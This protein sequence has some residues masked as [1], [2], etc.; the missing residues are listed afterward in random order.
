MVDRVIDNFAS[1]FF[2]GKLNKLYIDREEPC[3]LFN[4]EIQLNNTHDDFVDEIRTSFKKFRPLNARYEDSEKN[5]IKVV[6]FNLIEAET[7][8]RL[9]D[10]S[11][12]RN[13][14]RYDSTN[15]V[16]K[17]SRKIVD[18]IDDMERTEY[19]QEN[20]KGYNDRKHDGKDS[21]Q[22]RMRPGQKVL[23]YISE[24]DFT[25]TRTE[26]PYTEI[27]MKDDNKKVVDF[28]ETHETERMRENI[29]FFND[30]LAGYD[31]E[32]LADE[33]TQV[34]LE[35]VVKKKYKRNKRILKLDFEE[36]PFFD[37]SRVKLHRTFN[38]NSFEHGGRYYGNYVTGIFSKDYKFRNHLTIN[39]QP[40][41]ELDFGNLHP[42]M[43]YQLAGEQ[44]PEGDMYEIDI[45]NYGENRSDVKKV[46]NGMLNAEGQSIKQAKNN[47][48][49]SI[50]KKLTDNYTDTATRDRLTDYM[51]KLIDKHEAIEKHF[52]TGIAKKCQR[53]DSDIA[54]LVML[55][56]MNR[57]FK[58]LP[59][60]DSFIIQKRDENELK[61]A[62]QKA[63]RTVMS[64]QQ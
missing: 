7:T 24:T 38:D 59:V 46:L 3:Y 9:H 32:L 2:R 6:L 26:K 33:K 45:A 49:A 20:R 58:V 5:L 11:Y 57:D 28:I 21:Y 48:I 42:H 63:Y 12:S 16:N 1:W 53:L 18:I 37:T 30:K 60:H 64:L 22:S 15:S 56:L 52:F 31:I 39:G 61:E 13:S 43:V 36:L 35:Q 27:I 10:L 19:I 47:V 50:T 17:V 8:M 25:Y 54:E 4:E 29:Q 55:D 34:L 62:M 41:V 23:D 51:G 14:G 40:V 44:P